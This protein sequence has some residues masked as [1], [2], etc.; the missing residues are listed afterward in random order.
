MQQA[1]D[2]ALPAS[3][4]EDDSSLPKGETN[5]LCI[6][7]RVVRPK[8]ELIRFVAGP[9][10]DLVPD[11]RGK[12]PGR[13]VWVS[14]DRASL[15]LA[16]KRK[17][18]PRALK[19]EVRIAVDLITRVEALLM[20]EAL[21]ALSLANKAGAVVTGFAKI[22]AAKGAFCALVQA[23]DGSAAEINRLRGLCRNRGRQGAAPLSIDL[24]DAAQLGLSLGHEHV[25]HAALMDKDVGMVFTERANRLAHF[26]AGDPAGQASARALGSSGHSGLQQG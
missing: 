18:F 13:G 20:R 21:E 4:P 3:M 6:A 8:G 1:A 22:E 24:F 2:P 14:A 5:R 15:A 23:K 12:L 17:A 16:L 25:I 19:Q 10:G 11:L 9:E 7:T 26:Q